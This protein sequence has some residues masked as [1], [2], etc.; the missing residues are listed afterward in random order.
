MPSVLLSLTQFSHILSRF[1]EPLFEHVLKR[2]E[3]PCLFLRSCPARKL[4]LQ[5]IEGREASE[6]RARSVCRRARARERATRYLN[7]PN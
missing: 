4:N 3:S 2:V 1:S 7:L 5:N 6:R